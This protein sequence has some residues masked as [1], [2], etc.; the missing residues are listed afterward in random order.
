MM[1]NCCCSPPLMMM[2]TTR[3]PP[4][5]VLLASATLILYHSSH[6]WA[7]ELC[8]REWR[9]FLHRDLRQSSVKSLS[10]NPYY[11]LTH[12]LIH[13]LLHVLTHDYLTRLIGSL[14]LK[15]KTQ[16]L[17]KRNDRTLCDFIFN[18]WRSR[19]QFFLFCQWKRH[20]T[21]SLKPIVFLRNN[22]VFS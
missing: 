20:L 18:N 21:V 5:R 16:L 2:M 7:T 19:F 15:K 6:C 17:S 4:T 13:L 22:Y 9:D 11:S 12:C 10:Q 8:G 1:L 14:N 3:L